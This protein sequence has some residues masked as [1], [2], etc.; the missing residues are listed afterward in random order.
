VNVF[1]TLSVQPGAML[2]TAYDA[3]EKRNPI[4]DDDLRSKKDELANAVSDCI[5]AGQFEIQQEY[6]IK[7]LKA[8]SYGKT[9]LGSTVIDADK[10]S[11]V[12]RVLRV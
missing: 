10:L 11:E 8:A 3:F 4:E 2:F 6:Q 5:T 7:L 1:G 12:C 9:F